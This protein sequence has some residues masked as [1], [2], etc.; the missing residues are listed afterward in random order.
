MA[1]II[2]CYK[3]VKSEEDLRISADMSVDLSKAKG[4]ISDYDRN[5]IEAARLLAEATGSDLVGLTFGGPDAKPSLKDALS[6][7]LTQV[8]WV[9][10]SASA[11]AD[12]SVTSTILAA[13]IRKIDDFILV[14]CSEGAADT[15]AHEIGPRLSILLGIPVI[16]YAIQMK[17]EGEMLAAVRKLEDSLET[18]STRL[19]AVVTVLPEINPAPI[20]GLKAVLEAARKPS[21][22][23]K[24]AELGLSGDNLHRQTT[25]TSFKGYVMNRKKVVFKEGTA[26]ER[27]RALVASLR[28]EGML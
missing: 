12:G 24:I 27:A 17:A 25:V 23:W 3:W 21:T 8:F 5:A 9:N 2:V 1:R 14:V 6:R 22:E 10:D 15:Y 18:V 4:K 11:S 7:G 13:A 20:P 16:S 19:P 28:K 26:K